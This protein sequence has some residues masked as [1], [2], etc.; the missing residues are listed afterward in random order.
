MYVKGRVLIDCA[1]ERER[2]IKKMNV[3]VRSCVGL[4]VCQRKREYLG[5]YVL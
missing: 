3:R 4:C 1:G 5:M 2:G